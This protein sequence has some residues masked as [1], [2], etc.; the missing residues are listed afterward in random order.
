MTLADILK[1]KGSAV[2]TIEPGSG[3]DRAVAT[4]CEHNIGSLLVCERDVAEGER[5]VGILTER[6]ILHV[7]AERAEALPMIR[8]SEVMT[9]GLITAGPD[10][11]VE[12]VMGQMTKNRIRHLPVLSEGRLVGMVSIFP[13]YGQL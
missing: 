1:A 11:A 9:T 7:C 13:G 3:L 5:L 10:D 6:D 2:Y 8:V 12:T 4:L